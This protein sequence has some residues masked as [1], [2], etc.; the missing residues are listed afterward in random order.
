[1]RH[2]TRS[3]AADVAPKHPLE[4]RLDQVSGLSNACVL[5]ASKRA[6][7]VL[8]R[9]DASPPLLPGPQWDEVQENLHMTLQRNMY[10][11]HAPV[12]QMMER[13]LVSQVRLAVRAPPFRFG[14]TKTAPFTLQSPAPLSLGGFMRPSNI[15]LDILTG[16]D[17]TIN[18]GDVLTGAS[19]CSHRVLNHVLLMSR[20]IISLRTDRVQTAELGDFH[21]AMEKKLRL[22]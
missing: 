4:A 14:L 5:R 1:M 6:R 19:R 15:H 16:N 20:P 22:P 18:F 7:L 8:F 2:G 11:L 10:G 12:R 3:L 17:E 21:V 9:A 13:Q